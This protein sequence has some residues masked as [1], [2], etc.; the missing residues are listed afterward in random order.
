MVQTRRDKKINQ[1]VL[2]NL[3]SLF[4]ILYNSFNEY[5]DLKESKKYWS[6]ILAPY[7]SY[8][9]DHISVLKIV[10]DKDLPINNPKFEVP[11]DGGALSMMANSFF[12]LANSIN[13]FKKI[14]L[15]HDSQ[16]HIF[17]ENRSYNQKKFFFSLV[18][19]IFSF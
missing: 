11:I 15:N 14:K 7:L 5:H 10:D 8:I 18:N 9:N 17:K 1:L 4:D 12:P 16:V 2:N 19:F 13:F 6:I 3:N